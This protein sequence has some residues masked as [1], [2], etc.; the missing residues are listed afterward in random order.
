[1]R[2]LDPARTTGHRRSIAGRSITSRVARLDWAAI[3]RDLDDRGRAV[4]GR[5]L[6]PRECAGLVHMF[7]DQ[8]L[9][10]S[11]ID[12]A[13]HRFGAGEYKYF[14]EPLPVL[15]AA[16][17]EVLYGRLVPIANHW[18]EMLGASE[19]FPARLAGYRARC[20]ARGQRRP[21]PLLL[22]YGPGGYNCLHQDL[23]GP[24]AFPFQVTILL[25]RPGGDFAGGEFLLVEQRP[26]SQSRGEAVVLQQG[27]AIVFPNRYRPV[28]GTRGVYRVTV[29][30]GVSLIRSGQRTSLGVIFHDAE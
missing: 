16:L 17:R 2:R 13:R 23:Y 15:V 27:E 20:A 24:L 14:A 8:A 29:R 6:S 26:R 22:R 4:T 28:T 18:M 10:R 30:H 12:M 21:T 1:M 19:R 5:L 3:A 7:D 25:D 11:R 9:F